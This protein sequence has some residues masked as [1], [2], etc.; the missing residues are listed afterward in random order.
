MRLESALFSSSTGLAAHG[1]AMAVIGDNVSNANTVGFKAG[2]VQFSDLLAEGSEEQTSGAYRSAG[3]GVAV[4]Q[5]RQVHTGGTLESTGRV[6]DLAIDGN[7]YFAVGDPENPT[8]TRAGSLIVDEN[9]FLA[10]ASGANVLGFAPAAPGAEEGAERP[11]GL[12][13]MNNI[14]LGGRPST[15][16][17][18]S[19]NLGVEK[20]ITQVPADPQTFNEIAQAASFVSTFVAYDSLGATHSI[21]VAFF[22]TGANQWQAQAYIDGGEVGGEA[23]APVAIGD[24]A[25]LE[26]DNTGVIIPA[27]AAAAVINA[28]PAYANGA[29][30]GNFAIDLSQF[31]QYAGGTLTTGIV[32]DGEGSGDIVDF[33]IDSGGQ[34]FARL[35]SGT[36]APLGTLALA[37]FNNDEG[38]SRV[39]SSLFNE[40]A[41][42]GEAQFGEAGI[43]GFGTVRSGALELSNVDIADQFVNL[44]VYQRGYS[45]SSR[46]FSSAGEMLKDTI[47]MIG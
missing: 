23:G 46:V 39:G 35:S 28:A 37:N 20:P 25:T 3:N 42:S 8:Y 15:N 30:A 47:S 13:D 34:I 24:A 7:G 27:N 16:V 41:K 45:A 31:T 38:L 4:S 43:N 40:T 11:L 5:V 26:F 36:L 17:A 12:I 18:L 1:E 32:N 10:M 19:G 44:V 6:L 29:A 21:N 14:P 33:N 22:K 2:D 9:G